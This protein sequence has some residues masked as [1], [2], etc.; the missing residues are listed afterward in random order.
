MDRCRA[1][2]AALASAGI[3]ILAL[4]GCAA[5]PKIPEAAL[6]LPETTIDIRTMQ[7]HSFAVPSETIILAAA[8]AVLQDMEYNLDDVEKPLGVL[9][10]SKVSDAD[11]KSEKTG[12]FMLDVL[13]AAGGTSCNYSANAS[14]KQKITVTLVVLPS[15]ARKGEFVAR[16]TIQRVV[17]N[18]MQQVTL[19][20]PVVDA[21][22]YQ[23]IFD[24]LSQSIFL[25]VN[26][27]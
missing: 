11:S 24:K 21:K 1:R 17:F 3:A 7:S 25:Q 20:E 12:L 26:K 6:R 10:A 16:V 5:T 9:S 15:L 4:A 19:T 18:K 13:C 22:T 8:V 2:C 23:D 27:L 14:D